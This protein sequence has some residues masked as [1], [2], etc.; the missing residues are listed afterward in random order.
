MNPENRQRI[1]QRYV[2]PGDDIAYSGRTKLSKQLN[3]PADLINTDILSHNYA[4]GLHRETKRPRFFNPYFTKTLREQIQCDLID[5]RQYSKDND[6]YNLSEIRR[7]NGRKT[8]NR[9]TY[10]MEMSPEYVQE[11]SQ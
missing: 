4:Y 1:L 2:T 11:S 5:M 9:R 7:E 3:L 6:G 10:K 8:R